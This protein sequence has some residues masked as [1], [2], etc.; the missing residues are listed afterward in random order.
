MVSRLF[1]RTVVR[2]AEKKLDID[3]ELDEDDRAFLSSLWDRQ[4]RPNE[5][6]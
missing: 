4:E 5:S 2:R 6:S 3:Y 1:E